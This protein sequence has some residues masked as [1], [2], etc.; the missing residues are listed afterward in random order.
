MKNDEEQR[1][2]L[3]RIVH[4]L[5]SMARNKVFLDDFLIITTCYNLESTNYFAGTSR[6]LRSRVEIIENAKNFESV[7]KLCCDLEMNQA[8]LFIGGRGRFKEGS[9]GISHVDINTK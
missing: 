9:L 7:L 4:G 2:V 1:L 3:Q 5:V 8:W 6:L